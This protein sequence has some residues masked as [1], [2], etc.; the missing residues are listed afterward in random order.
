MQFANIL[1]T[2]KGTPRKTLVTNEEVKLLAMNSAHFSA[3]P[4]DVP[5]LSLYETLETKVRKPGIFSTPQKMEVCRNM[6][7]VIHTDVD[8]IS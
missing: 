8:S 3:A 6:P 7:V 2:G 4:I 5:V 1:L